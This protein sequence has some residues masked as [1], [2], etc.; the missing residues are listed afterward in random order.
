[1]SR[2]IN[3][4]PSSETLSVGN[5]VSAGLRI[6]RDNFKVYYWEALKSYL[7]I[8]VPV[9]GWAKF[10]AIEALIG[11]L[12]FCE[13]RETPESL[14]DAR[15]QVMPKMWLFLVT[16][17][18]MSLIIFAR[19]IVFAIILV[20]LGL[21]FAANIQGN[22]LMSLV[23]VL[24]M[25]FFFFFIIFAYIRLISRISFGYLAIAID[26]ISEA[27]KAINRSRTITQGFVVKIQIIFFIAFLLTIPFSMASNLGSL[28]LQRAYSILKCIMSEDIL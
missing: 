16:G 8:F 3:R 11:R 17:I 28:F 21:G 19:L 6:Y 12:A 23:F 4:R 20:L 5:V 26:G 15:R 18:L 25:V 14:A 22:G 13:V 1:M 10:L 7:W 9:Y 2:E 27:T 24:L